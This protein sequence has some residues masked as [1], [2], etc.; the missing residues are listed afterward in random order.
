M[1][2][3]PPYAVGGSKA[4]LEQSFGGA[5]MKDAL[6]HLG[7]QFWKPTKEGGLIRAGRTNEVNDAVIADLLRCRSIEVFKTSL[8][9]INAD[10]TGQPRFPLGSYEW[11]FLPTSTAENQNAFRAQ[12]SPG[13][14][15]LHF[16]GFEELSDLPGDVIQAIRETGVALPGDCNEDI[17]APTITLAME[18]TVLWP[19][20]HQMYRVTRRISAI[21]S[22]DPN[23]E[24]SVEV[25]SNESPLGEG[26]GD[27]S[28][29]WSV[30]LNGDGAY[31]VF[32]RAERSG[33]GRGRVYMIAV[34]CT[35]ASG[36]T[37]VETA[38][39]PVP[40]ISPFASGDL[41]GD[42]DVDKDDLNILL[43]SRN[44]PADGPFDPRDFDGD[45]KI[46]VLDA[47]I[48]ATL[49]TRPGGAVR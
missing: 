22:C 36:K 27:T 41:D 25:T 17:W 15:S 43:A 30:V 33:N 46:T 5:G 13:E 49:F 4:R 12:A 9:F 2:W 23:P 34:T 7:L 35:D 38:T 16:I 3:V 14:L 31:D 20:D 42:A 47:R 39:V 11:A 40:K 28:Q 8:A 21:D 37:S 24:I 26:S 18:T 19:P 1:T 45:G 44:Q 10:G 6:T 48:L 29:D 32:L